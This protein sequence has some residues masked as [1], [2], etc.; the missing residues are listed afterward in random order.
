MKKFLAIFWLLGSSLISKASDIEMA[1]QFRS[2][3]KIYVVVAVFA[4]LMLGFFAY[5]YRIEQKISKKE[6]EFQLPNGK[7]SSKTDS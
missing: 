7:P 4:I 6:K 3:G 1:D 5:M 2:D